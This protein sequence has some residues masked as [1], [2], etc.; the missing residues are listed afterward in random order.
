MKHTALLIAMLG[1]SSLSSGCAVMAAGAA[2]GA[3]VMAVQNRSIGR[4]IDDAAISNTVKARLMAYDSSAYARVDVEVAEAQVL[5]SGTTATDQNRLDAERIA[6]G[7][8]GVDGVANQIAV[9]RNQGLFGSAHDEWI[10]AR[11]RAK[12]ISDPA[13]KGL[14]F[15]IETHDGVVYLM[16]LASSEDEMRRAA[17]GASYIGGVKRVISYMQ[18]RPLPPGQEM[19][20]SGAAPID[21]AGAAAPARAEGGLAG[22]MEPDASRTY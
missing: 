13:V 2:A 18:V 3:G 9:G 4:G 20:R 16:G 15:N 1:A 12:L 14:N 7:V 19:A 6:W 5:L 21:M 11:V 8:K 17:E 22:A 10:T